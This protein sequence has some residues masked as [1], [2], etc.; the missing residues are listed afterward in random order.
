M[1]NPAVR[2]RPL[3]LYD[4]VARRTD[5]R[6]SAAPDDFRLGGCCYTDS[7]S[8][9]DNSILYCLDSA[10]ERAYF[11]ILDDVDAAYRS[12]FLYSAQY[13]SAKHILS[14]PFE[15]LSEFL[16]SSNLFPTLIFSIGRC[17]STLLVSLLRALGAPAVSEPS[18]FRQ[19]IRSVEDGQLLNRRLVTVAVQTC[20]A[21]IAQHFGGQPV[22]KL[23]SQC[24][25]LI[26][27]ITYALPQYHAIFMFRE[28]TTWARSM[29]RAFFYEPRGLAHRLAADIKSYDW[30]A[31]NHSG[32]Q[33]V[34]YEDLVDRPEEVLRQLGALTDPVSAD[35]RRRIYEV[36]A[37]DSQ[38]GT[39]LSR[40]NLSTREFRPNTSM[41][42]RN[43]WKKVRPEALIERYGL[44]RLG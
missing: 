42:F 5:V 40:Q 27:A 23:Q 2:K 8:I 9:V 41:K 17:G 32:V 31:Q 11:T 36:M 6:P 15:R 1:T 19:L 29:C 22:I 30:L 37:A 16:D 38:E 28:S 10:E 25:Y 33:L 13:E 3:C 35:T 44:A 20:T 14:V 34:W 24:N 12:P 7:F 21:S 39:G 18:V 26:E 4:V 43:E